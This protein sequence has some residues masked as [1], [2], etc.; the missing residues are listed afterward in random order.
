[1]RLRTFFIILAL[2]CAVCSCGCAPSS[3]QKTDRWPELRRA[4]EAERR[5]AEE[6]VAVREERLRK[7]LELLDGVWEERIPRSK[8][9]HWYNA[10]TFSMDRLAWNRIQTIDGE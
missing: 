7:E 8:G 2:L 6:A 3:A 5:A 10:L 4:A 1:M 9:Q